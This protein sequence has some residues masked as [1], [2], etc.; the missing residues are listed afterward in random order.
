MDIN[1]HGSANNSS[2]NLSRSPPASVGSSPPVDTPES[3]PVGGPYNAP[4]A[5]SPMLDALSTPSVS[6]ST[7]PSMANEWARGG[8]AGSPGNLISLMGESPPTQP[9]SFEDSARIHLGSPLQRA[10]MSSSPGSPSPPGSVRRPLSYQME[11]HFQPNGTPPPANTASYR[12]GSLQSQFSHARAGSHPPL[13][14]QPQAHFFGAPDLDLTLTPQSGMRAGDRGYFF[15]FDRLPL[16]ADAK[17]ASENVVLAGYE[18]GLE[19]HAVRRRGLEPVA[20]LKGLRGGVHYAKILPWTV[21]RHDQSLFPL[22]AVVVHGPVVGPHSPAITVHDDDIKADGTASPRSVFTNQEGFLGRPAPAA[23]AYQTSV[24][25]YSLKT[26]KLVDVLLEAPKVALSAAIA[27]TSP[28][29]QPPQPNG[30]FSIKADGGTIAVCSG[31]TGECWVYLQLLEPQNGH[32]FACVGK[33]WTCLQQGVRGDVV[34]ENENPHV[35]AP[36]PRVNP[37]TPI[38]AIHRR[39]LAYCPASPSSQLTLRAHLPVPIVGRAPGVSSA[40]PPHLPAIS[41]A[42]DL[43]ISDS[44]VN[45]IMRETTQEFIQGAKWVGQ[46]GLSAWNSYWNKPT[47]P[48][49]QQGRSP[50]QSWSGAPQSR[51]DAGQFP[52]THGA[53][54]SSIP[55]DPGLVSVLDAE[56]LASSATIH[57][58]TTFAT[59]MGCSFLSFSPTGLSIFTASS[60]GDVQTVWDLLRVQHT[61]S[62]PLQSTI[63]TTDSPG[64][65]V[66]QLAQFSRMTVARIVDVVWAGPQGERIAMVTERGT[67]HL[68]DMPFSAF[69]WPPPRRRK[70]A[71]ENAGDPA[72]AAT[73]AVSI[74]SGAFGA[75]YQAAKPFVTRSRRSSSNNPPAVSGN[76]LRDSAAHGGRVIAASITSSIG[77]TGMAIN[78]LRHTGENRVSLPLSAALPAS[79]RVAWIRSRKTYHLCGAGGGIVRMFP[80]KTRQPST[81]SGK[82]SSRTSRGRDMKVPSLPDDVIP[83]AV[84]QILDHGAQDEYLDL[85][86]GEMETGN[87]MT[88]NRSRP[89]SQLVDQLTTSAIPQAEIE[90]SAPYQPF[91]TDRRVAISEYVAEQVA[92]LDAVSAMLAE[93]SVEERPVSRKKRNRQQ[94]LLHS[95]DRD[96]ASDAATWVFG[97]DISVI[98]RDMGVPQVIDEDA[99]GPNDHMALPP[100]AMERVMQYGDEEQIVVTTRRR[101]GGPRPGEDEDGF[102]E[103]DCEV[104]DFADQRV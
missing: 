104:L 63:P 76:M 83:P 7:V 73:S 23:N 46:Q 18:G 53:A 97:Q 84:R 91:H 9:S 86:D 88:L 12:R 55:K 11:S 102:F 94:P 38:F 81:Q 15:G 1:G 14:H 17:A 13:P 72:E 10:Y 35:P 57:P 69:M 5:I 41:S 2:A 74:A 32:S 25:V 54:G 19:V 68:L 48:T 26:N 6:A 43:P 31:V 49:P 28:I 51:G 20:S 30:A 70:V 93:T 47:S 66:R 100:S 39:W 82:R 3:R 8:M 36:R 98:R 89:Q 79:G 92:Q 101:R 60:K 56:A 45:K 77:R 80:S 34:E 52:P 62:S 22:I 87:T 96:G 27:M 67:V 4:V 61:K 65:Q 37:Q 44:V 85:S 103:D 21:G 90:S 75:A 71:K 16:S 50:P 33:L 59:P 58:I 29:F 78:Q 99:A 24:Q 64:P 40:T 42:V 95:S